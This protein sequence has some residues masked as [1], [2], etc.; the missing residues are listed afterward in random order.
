MTRS[1]GVGM[2]GSPEEES[3]AAGVLGAR[4]LRGAANVV[5]RKNAVAVRG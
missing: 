4:S 3:S 1:M 2:D 5:K